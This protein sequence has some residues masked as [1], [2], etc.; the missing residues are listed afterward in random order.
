MGYGGMVSGSLPQLARE[1]SSLG[2]YWT[3]RS[4]L[5]A[6][7]RGVARD[8]LRPDSSTSVGLRQKRSRGAAPGSVFSHTSREKDVGRCLPGL[9]GRSPTGE[10]RLRVATPRRSFSLKKNGE[11]GIGSLRSGL[12]PKRAPG[13][14]LPI[15][16]LASVARLPHRGV[17]RPASRCYAEAPFRIAKGWRRG[18]DSNPRYPFR[19]T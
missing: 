13:A 3:V 4:G 7:T 16:L 5:M 9:P 11:G 10:A 15:S 1:A 17:V 14:H 6:A 8:S 12:R 19:Y 2:R 18:R